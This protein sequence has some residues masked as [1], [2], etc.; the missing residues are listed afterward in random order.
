MKCKVSLVTPNHLKTT[1]VKK[2][3]ITLTKYITGQAAAD[4][5]LEKDHQNGPYHLAPHKDRPLH[6]LLLK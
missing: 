4:L 2:Q 5:P 1:P 6:H 3:F